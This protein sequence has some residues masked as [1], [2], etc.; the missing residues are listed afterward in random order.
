[1]YNILIVGVGGQGTLL[2]SRVLGNYAVL[3]GNDCKLSEVHGMS[4]RGGSVVTHVRMGENVLSPI[5]SAG[6]A[7]IVIAFEKLEAMRFRH[8]LKPDGFMV[9]NDQEIMPMPVITGAREY[10]HGIIDDMRKEGI[11]MLVIDAA[12]IAVECG[13]VKVANTVMLGALAK[14]LGFKF[15][16]I[17]QALVMTV[18][19]KF[20]DVN[21]IAL[22]RGYNE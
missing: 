5:V 9:V 10:P 11:N 15:E 8:F 6:D 7:D 13:N 14:N 18:P 20:L 21:L 16:D 12:K 22:E 3:T 19:A 17:K 4:Q 2:A 1:M